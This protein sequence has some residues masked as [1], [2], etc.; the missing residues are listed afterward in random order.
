MQNSEH[1]SDYRTVLFLCS[2]QILILLDNITILYHWKHL[3]DR[4][5]TSVQNVEVF[6]I[7]MQPQ[8]INFLKY[9]E[10]SFNVRS[11]IMSRIQ[12][13]FQNIEVYYLYAAAIDNFLNYNEKLF[14][15]ENVMMNRIHCTLQ[16]AKL[17]YI[18]T[19]AIH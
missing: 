12:N 11:V 2:Q 6:I 8:Y 19:V 1:F 4:I 7:F 13:T 16:N 17:Y 5:Q 3:V 15:D 10:K 14:T 18:Y 9:Y